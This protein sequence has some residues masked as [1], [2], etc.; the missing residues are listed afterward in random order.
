MFLVQHVAHSKYSKMLTIINISSIQSSEILTDPSSRVKKWWK[1]E[2]E[3]NKFQLSVL[4]AQRRIISV[5]GHV[6]PACCV[7]PVSTALFGLHNIL[8]FFK[9]YWNCQYFT[10]FIFSIFLR[11]YFYQTEDNCPEA[12]SQMQHFTAFKSMNFIWLNLINA[13]I[14]KQSIYTQKISFWFLLKIRKLQEQVQM[15]PQ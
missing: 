14:L 3:I 1:T 5:R 11:V 7:S 9:K 15:S 2:K 10:T 12:R 8:T 13:N 6:S 4:T